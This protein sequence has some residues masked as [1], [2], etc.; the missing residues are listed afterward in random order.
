MTE[1]Q[2]AFNLAQNRGDVSRIDE[3]VR[4]LESVPQ[5]DP[6]A[7]DLRKQLTAFLLRAKTIETTAE[8]ETVASNNKAEAKNANSIRSFWNGL[9]LTGP[10]WKRLAGIMVWLK[11][12]KANRPSPDGP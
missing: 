7:D 10:G 2:E 5:L 6:T 12:P 11:R 4:N 1:A 8:N 9:R 3:A